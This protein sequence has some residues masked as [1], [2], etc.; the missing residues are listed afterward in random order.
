MQKF[1]S[2]EGNNSSDGTYVELGFR[3]AIIIV[4]NIDASQNWVIVDDE[5]DSYNVAKNTLRPNS[6]L[7]GY[8]NNDFADFLSSGFKFRGNEAQWNNAQTYIYAAWAYQPMN[9]LYGAQSN[10]R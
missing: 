6:A 9:N 2:Y 8:S 7:I 5:R 1:G 10:A 3:P 4:K